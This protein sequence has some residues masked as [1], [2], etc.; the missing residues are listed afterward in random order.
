MNISL[1]PLARCVMAIRWT[2]SNGRIQGVGCKAN[3][4][5]GAEPACCYFVGRPIGSAIQPPLLFVARL[6]SGG[7]CSLWARFIHF[8]H[9]PR[10]YFHFCSL[11]CRLQRVARVGRRPSRGRRLL[12]RFRLRPSGPT[13]RSRRT[14]VRTCSK[15]PTASTTPRVSSS[16]S[17]NP[18]STIACK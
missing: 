8:S 17:E 3:E 15:R 7:S 5:T 2:P 14:P 16:K 4:T 6:V 10:F 13:S 12:R 18:S 9:S 11:L 1:G